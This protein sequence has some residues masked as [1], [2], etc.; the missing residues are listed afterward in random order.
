MYN[1]NSR[2]AYSNKTTSPVW[3]DDEFAFVVSKYK[4]RLCLNTDCFRRCIELQ[5]SHAGLVKI[6][7]VMKVMSPSKKKKC[8]CRFVEMKNGLSFSQIVAPFMSTSVG[9]R[10]FSNKL[11]PHFDAMSLVAQT[12]WKASWE[13]VLIVWLAYVSLLSFRQL[14]LC[15]FLIYKSSSRSFHHHVSVLPFS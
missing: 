8:S 14:L 2:K 10:Y 15:T 11:S 3:V 12:P 1:E 13:V 4:T 6:R 9:C 7:Q 5:K